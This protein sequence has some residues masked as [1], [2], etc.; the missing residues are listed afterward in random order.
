MQYEH[1][2]IL[3]IM[4]DGAH[5]S[6]GAIQIKS[7]LN[8]ETLRA[9]LKQMVFDGL[10]ECDSARGYVAFVITLK[11]LKEERDSSPSPLY[12]P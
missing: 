10:L 11:G 3:T 1:H 12:R 6:F 9:T 5:R 7:Q 2:Q 8:P 4:A